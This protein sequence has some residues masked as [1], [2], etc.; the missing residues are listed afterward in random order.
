MFVDE[1][2]VD[3]LTVGLTYMTSECA[4]AHITGQVDAGDWELRSDKHMT[5]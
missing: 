3:N 5:V 1:D 2:C 4:T